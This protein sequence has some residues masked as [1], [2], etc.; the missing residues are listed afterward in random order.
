MAREGKPMPALP[1]E[2]DAE[3]TLEIDGSDITP[4]KFLRG[5]RAFFG[6]LD[7]VTREVGNEREP[8]HWVVQVKAGSNLVGVRPAPNTPLPIVDRV[9][10]LVRRGSRPSKIAPRRRRAFRFS[11]SGICATSA[12]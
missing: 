9:L 7:A 11:R 12:T 10:G 8:L 1:N 4:E 6:T 3:L 2:I 5:V